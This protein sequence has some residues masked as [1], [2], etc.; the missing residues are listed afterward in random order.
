M[1]ILAVITCYSSAVP[2]EST[3]KR[4]A[5]EEEEAKFDYI[6]GIWRKCKHDLTARWPA[7]HSVKVQ[8]TVRGWDRGK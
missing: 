5:K 4:V 7:S 6:G 1:Y 8:K 2:F 3:Q